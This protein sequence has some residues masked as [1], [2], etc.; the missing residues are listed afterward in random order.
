MAIVDLAHDLDRHGY[1]ESPVHRL[2]PRV[3]LIAGLACVLTAASFP[4]YSVVGPVPLLLVPAGLLI[5]GRVPLRLILRFALLAGP[6]VLLIALF[7]PLLD[8]GPPLRFGP[9]RVAPGWLSAL[10]IILRGAC[11]LGVALVLAATAPLP[12][13]M[14]ALGRLGLPRALVVQLFLLYR[15]LFVLIAEGRGLLA[16]RALRDPDRRLPR[17]GTARALLGTLLIRTWH[18]AQR[19]HHSMLLRGFAGEFPVLAG[20]RLRLVDGIFLLVAL[21]WC[22]GARFL[23]LSDWLGSA[24]LGAGA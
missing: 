8:Q 15:Y 14:R 17:P 12:H 2:D 23:P 1:A 18:R 9:W 7:N 19:I 4:K 21:A 16:A 22:V 5:L 3:K 24:A 13:L 20:T 6:F 10:S 11:A